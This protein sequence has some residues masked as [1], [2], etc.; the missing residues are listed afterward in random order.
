MRQ[1][2]AGKVAYK[3][4]FPALNAGLRAGGPVAV[5]KIRGRG[6]TKRQVSPLESAGGAWTVA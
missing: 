2:N 5:H 4:K 6:V 1:Y 3:P